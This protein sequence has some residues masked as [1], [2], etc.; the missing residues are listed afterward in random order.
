MLSDLF[1]TFVYLNL[2]TVLIFIIMHK[3]I[4]KWHEKINSST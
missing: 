4:D 2:V 1:Y 3:K